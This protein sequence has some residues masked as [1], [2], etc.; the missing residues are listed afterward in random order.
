M[1]LCCT[2]DQRDHL[3]PLEHALNSDIYAFGKLFSAF[4]TC[5]L[6]WV[7]THDLPV[8]TEQQE[9]SAQYVLVRCS[10]SYCLYEYGLWL[11]LFKHVA[12]SRSV[13]TLDFV[14]AQ[15]DTSKR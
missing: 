9:Q 13:V 4:I 7:R 14:T 6:L 8:T 5:V 3:Q 15:T 11:A 1:W 2:L 10:S 12:V